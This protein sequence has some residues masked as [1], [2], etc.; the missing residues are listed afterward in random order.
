MAGRFP[1]LYLTEA[2]PASAVL[3]SGL[4]ARL[5]AEAPNAAVTVVGSPDSAPLF[6]DTPGLE[7]LIVLP[8]ESRLSWL[9]LWAKVRGRHWGLVVDLRGSKLSGHLRRQRRA[10]RQ[11][12]SET[13][14]DH[15]VVSA[16]RVLML[17]DVP[18]PRLAFS[19][20]T[21]AAV[22]EVMADH[23]GPVLAVAP[24][25]DWIGKRW[26]AERFTKV[27]THLLGPGGP[28]EGGR[29]LIVGAAEDRD[30]AHTI[31]F[32]VSRDRVIEA[33]GRLDPLQSAC[34]MSRADLVLAADSVWMQLAVASG[35]PTVGVFGPSDEARVGPWGGRSV[36]GPRSLKDFRAVDPDLN[37]AIQHMM[38][39]PAE[40]VLEAA[41]ALLAERAGSVERMG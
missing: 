40:P 38:D 5:V 23:P 8:D 22:D 24:G 20:A 16:A 17:D 14:G 3:S 10:V 27:A 39:L 29:L 21:I 15:A 35:T 41:V 28:L 19:P 33:Q 31:R 34:A 36:R 37:Q 6:R 2:D 11:P 32:A 18:A 26:P 9:S 25:V 30:A 7:Q 4:L 13:E 1:I 12:A